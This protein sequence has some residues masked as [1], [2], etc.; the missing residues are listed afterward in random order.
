MFTKYDEFGNQI[1]RTRVT[2]DCSNDPVLVEQHHV[3][4]VDINAIVRKHGI[5]K[6]QAT[7]ALY[8]TPEFEF[9]AVTGNDFQEAMMILTKAQDSFDHLPHEVRD[10]FDNNPAKFL[11][12]VQNPDN[13]T[14]MQDMGLA[15]RDPVQQPIEV[16]VT[17]PETPPE[18]IP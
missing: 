11:D 13:L 17:N 1:E 4:E 5:D 15:Q 12:F 2:V 3:A 16:I 7:A 9:D 10:R 18:V 6:I 8:Q 14:E